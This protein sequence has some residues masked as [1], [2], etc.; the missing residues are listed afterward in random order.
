MGSPSIFLGT[1]GG[2]Y[3]CAFYLPEG[4]GGGGGHGPEEFWSCSVA[5][6][7][8]LQLSSCLTS[9]LRP[10]GFLSHCRIGFWLV[11]SD[12]HPGAF[13]RGVAVT[14]FHLHLLCG[15]HFHD[16]LSRRI[17]ILIRPAPHTFHLPPQ[18]VSHGCHA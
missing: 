12:T 8:L 10:C 11:G 17:P 15:A 14:K 7:L 5:A 4:G 16:I 9:L 1:A 3:R 6:H 13:V 18:P 2:R